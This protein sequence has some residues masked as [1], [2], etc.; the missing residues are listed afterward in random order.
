MTD[1]LKKFVFDA[2]PVR[3][4]LVR[5]EATWQEVLRRR[6][7]PAAV[8][9]L[10]GEMMAAA[11]LLSA[12]LKF[13]GALVMQLHGD[14]PVR[15]LVVE[16]NSDLSMRA[17]AKIVEGA[18]IAEDAT[19]ASMVN[20]QGHGRFAITLDPQDKLPGQQ[21]YQ[22]I[23]PLSDENG[24]LASMTEVLEHYMQTSEQLD[25][26][27]W[28][29]ANEKVASGMLLQR[30][31]SYGGAMEGRPDREPAQVGETGQP[32]HENAPEQDLDTWERVCQL[33]KTLRREELLEQPIDT[34]I[35]RLY[36]EELEAAGIRMFEPQAPHFRCSC[37]RLR[38]GAMLRTLGQPEIDSILQERG[39]VEI[40]CEFCGQHYSFDAVD[41]AQLFA[42]DT[43][44]QGIQGASDQRH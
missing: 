28:L 14:G 2:A 38:V 18:E 35:K 9:T 27:L 44:A 4:E 29:A 21:P 41:C 30:L 19:L 1:E 17:T 42:Q 33:G 20:V 43:V 3:G 15:M 39:K 13:N 22:G 34:L 32:L 36:W 8:Q 6:R 23:V 16:C 11:A 10:L 12:N 40:D 31:P 5:L 25:T 24:P 7:Y 37:S 26:R